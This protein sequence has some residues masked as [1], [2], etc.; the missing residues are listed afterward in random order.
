MY[1]DVVRRSGYKRGVLAVTGV[2][3]KHK[4][5]RAYRTPPPLWL[6]NDMM[7]APNGQHGRM[8]AVGRAGALSKHSQT[9]FSCASRV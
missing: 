8:G 9:D 4:K 5:D 3:V 2:E 6:P 7:S 1:G